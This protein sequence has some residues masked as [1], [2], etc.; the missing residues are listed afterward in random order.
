MSDGQVD[1]VGHVVNLAARIVDVAGPG[2]VLYAAC[3]SWWTACA[4][5]PVR[6][7]GAGRQRRHPRRGPLVSSGAGIDPRRRSCRRRRQEP[8]CTA[9]SGCTRRAW[10]RGVGVLAHDGDLRYAQWR[11]VGITLDSKEVERDP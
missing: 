3:A 4:G 9:T 7:A 8:S 2:E 1:P 10:P 11:D 6:R 5:P